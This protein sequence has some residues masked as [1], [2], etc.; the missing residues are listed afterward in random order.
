MKFDKITC[1]GHHLHIYTLLRLKAFP[2]D[3]WSPNCLNTVI[4]KLKFQSLVVE[5]TPIALLPNQKLEPDKFGSVR[6]K[7]FTSNRVRLCDRPLSGISFPML[8]LGFAVGPHLNGV[9]RLP[10][11]TRRSL[12]TESKRESS[13]SG[14]NL[15]LKKN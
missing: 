6:S 9:Y 1:K 15:S 3:S 5:N 14:L 7:R 10:L 8:P 13:W 11:A 12:E 2:L 4:K